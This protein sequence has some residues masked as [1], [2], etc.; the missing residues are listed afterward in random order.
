LLKI[1]DL[2]EAAAKVTEIAA[3]A[4]VDFVSLT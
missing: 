1:K 4:G 2:L 3:V